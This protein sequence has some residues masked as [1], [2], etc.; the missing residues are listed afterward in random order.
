MYLPWFSNLQLLFSGLQ[1][2][3]NPVCVFRHVGVDPRCAPATSTAPKWH[4]TQLVLDLFVPRDPVK[5]VTWCKMWLTCWISSWLTPLPRDHRRPRYMNRTQTFPHR[6]ASAHWS[7]HPWWLRY[8]QI[9][10]ECRHARE[11]LMMHQHSEIRFQTVLITNR[12]GSL[13]Q[14]QEC[15]LFITPNL[16]NRINLML[17]TSL[18]SSLSEISLV[19][20]QPATETSLPARLLGFRSFTPRLAAAVSWKK[21]QMSCVPLKIFIHTTCIP[22]LEEGRPGWHWHRDLPALRDELALCHWRCAMNPSD[23]VR[24]RWLFPHQSV[25]KRGG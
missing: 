3:L 20:P 12:A 16:C 9:W 6:A 7:W 15:N 1:M 25:A 4:D 11:L 13:A 23:I 21:L 17:L 22:C 10:W 24:A 8:N 19:C 5:V 14:C 2:P 18:L